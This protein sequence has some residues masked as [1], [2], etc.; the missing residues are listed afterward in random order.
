MD[1]V[2]LVL[3]GLSL[4]VAVVGTVMSN[5][6]SSEALAES[7]KAVT[8]ALWSAVQEAVQRLIG[9]DPTAEPIGDRLANLRILM[10]ALVD[11]LDD[12][13]GLDK[14]LEAERVLG[15]TLGRQIMEAAQ[16]GD[17][18]EQRL[19]NLDPLLRWA[20]AMSSNLRHF[21]SAG[22]DAKAGVRL[23][24]NAEH[25]VRLIHDKHGWELPPTPSSGD[26]PLA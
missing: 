22:Y 8:A 5:R 17:S 24:A 23:R 1:V 18:V 16:P 9:F 12:W 11:E 4:V 25:L 21:R 6:R 26:Q 20:D 15:A 3:S 7:R 10:I 2:A 13:A 19:T 14:W